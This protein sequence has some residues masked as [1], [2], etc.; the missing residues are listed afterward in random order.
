MEI[1]ELKN[2]KT[3]AEEAIIEILNNFQ[4]ETETEIKGIETEK[5]CSIPKQSKFY[6]VELEISI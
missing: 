2:K 3:K 4:T 1:H 5:I 6:K